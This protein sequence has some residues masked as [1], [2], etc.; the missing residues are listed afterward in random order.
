VSGN[1]LFADVETI[2][3]QRILLDPVKATQLVTDSLNEVLV[4]AGY[5]VVEVVLSKYPREILVRVVCSESKDE[6]DE[7]FWVDDRSFDTVCADLSKQLGS[8]VRVPGWYWSK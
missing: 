7:D 3:T 1:A 5:V 6:P 2:T 4:C 8:S